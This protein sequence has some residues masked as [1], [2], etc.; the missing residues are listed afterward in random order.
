MAQIYVFGHRDAATPL[1]VIE[2]SV[3]PSASAPGTTLS[4][5]AR[6]FIPAAVNATAAAVS[7]YAQDV[8]LGNVVTMP[9]NGR[10]S[11]GTVVAKRTTLKQGAFNPF[12]TKA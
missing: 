2:L 10:P 11:A 7:T 3:R 8:Q 4:L 1:P 5:S 6:H 9:V 12:D